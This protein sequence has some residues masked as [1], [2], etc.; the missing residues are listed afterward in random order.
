MN[1]TAKGRMLLVLHKEV[2]CESVW[3]KPSRLGGWKRLIGIYP[4]TKDV[5]TLEVQCK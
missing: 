3:E 5:E 2:E 1:T 4:I